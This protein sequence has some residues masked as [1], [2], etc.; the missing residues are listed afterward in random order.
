MTWSFS[1]LPNFANDVFEGALV[2]F[3]TN[4]NSSSGKIYYIGGMI[5]GY[6]KPEFLNNGD[7]MILK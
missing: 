7:I 1:N 3:D 2:Q 4:A 5:K 6:Q